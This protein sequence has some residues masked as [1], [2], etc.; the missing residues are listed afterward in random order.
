MA[1]PTRRES[2]GVVQ[3]AQDGVC[4]TA[5]VKCVLRGKTADTTYRQYADNNH[6]DDQLDR[7]KPRRFRAQ[8]RGFH[9]LRSGTM[10]M[11]NRH[12]ANLLS[13][14]ELRLDDIV[15]CYSTRA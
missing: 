2:M 4:K 10:V 13:R 5:F 8:T 12:A 15:Y 6:D 1:T 9:G 14:L 11:N 7:R 3:A